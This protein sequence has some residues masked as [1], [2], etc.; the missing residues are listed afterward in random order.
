MQWSTIHVL[1]PLACYP[2][3]HQINGLIILICSGEIESMG[4][5]IGAPFDNKSILTNYTVGMFT[6]SYDCPPLFFEFL[7][8]HDIS[9]LSCV[10]HRL[11]HCTD[12]IRTKRKMENIS[13]LLHFFQSPYTRILS[14][15]RSYQDGF[16]H[17]MRR[18]F[19]VAYDFFS[20]LNHQSVYY[21]DMSHPYS[22]YEKR[23]HHFLERIIS[24]DLSQIQYVI[25]QILD[26]IEMSTSLTYCNLGMFEPYLS[27]EDLHRRIQHHPS[28]YHL[29][30]SSVPTYALQGQSPTSLYRMEDGSFEWRHYAPSYV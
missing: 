26:A 17:Q 3:G 1:I 29:E 22:P 14:M 25:Q 23:S 27:K 19:H 21:L 2:M 4:A 7:D 13:K 24:S 12:Q 9:E 15:H 28:L 5:S 6:G 11:T 20:Y 30:I 16:E 8:D 10:S 18:L